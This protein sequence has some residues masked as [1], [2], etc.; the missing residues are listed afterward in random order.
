MQMLSKMIQIAVNAHEGQFDKGGKPY[1]LHVLRV[2]N[3]LGQDAD[4]EL[5]CIAVGHDLLED[6]NVSVSD[7]EKAGFSSGVI[8]AIEVLTKTPGESYEAYK[9]GV[10]CFKETCLVKAAD[11]QD[12]SDIRRLKGITKKD[13]DRMAKYHQFYLEIQEALYN[14]F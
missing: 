6:T 9:T 3:N 10:L 5:Q 13:L 11:L 14:D 1:I 12:N 4:E 2:M 7:L 8:R